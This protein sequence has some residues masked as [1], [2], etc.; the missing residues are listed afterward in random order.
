MWEIMNK[1]FFSFFCNTKKKDEDGEEWL[2]KDRGR[3]ER[4]DGKW[5]VESGGGRQMVIRG[6]VG[7]WFDKADFMCE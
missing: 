4:R 5:R 7:V 2:E 1:F 6:V 3:V